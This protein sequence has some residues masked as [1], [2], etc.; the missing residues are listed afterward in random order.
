MEGGYI[1][2]V[3]RVL[4]G[5]ILILSVIQIISFEMAIKNVSADS[6]WVQTTEADFKN[7][8]LNNV[9]VTTSGEVEL[10]LQ[11]KFVEDDFTDESKISYK[12]NVVVD[13][14]QGEANLLKIVKPFG[15]LG[16]SC[17]SSVQQTDDD[18]YIITGNMLIKTDSSGNEQWNKA[19]DGTWGN[20]VQQTTGGGYI[21]TGFTDFYN[22]GYWDVRLIK[23]DSSGNTQWDK[24]FGGSNDEFGLSV[25]QTFDGGYIVTGYTNSYGAGSYDAFLIKTDATGNKEWDKTFG[26]VDSDEG[27]FVQQ[28]SEGGYIITGGTSSY[29]AGSSDVWLIKTDSSGN[30]QWN[31]T[32]GGS[33]GDYGKSLQQT[34][35]GA[36]T[37]T[38]TTYS[39]GAGFSDVWLIRTNSSGSEQWNRTFGGSGWD[40]GHSV[41]QTSEGDYIVTGVDNSYGAGFSDV[42]LIRR[43]SSSPTDFRWGIH[44][45]RGFLWFCRGFPCVAD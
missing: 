16:I 18:G 15:G 38:G 37:I 22:A 7:G 39:Y 24:I 25:K 30:E 11:T 44:Y 26:G 3:L 13:S 8:T 21:I 14:S 5:I 1:N 43:D 36:Y 35:D 42:W 2:K 41:N 6:S 19:L 45:Y 17:G 27:S 33:D 20:S 4:L 29:G 12:E 34:S 40:N 10:A 9:I 32:F 31:R 28:T 23:T